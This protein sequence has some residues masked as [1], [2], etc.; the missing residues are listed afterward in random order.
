MKK[1]RRLITIILIVA[2]V[3]TSSI[4]ILGATTDPTVSQ[5]EL[6]N[7]DLS[8]QAATEG[9]VLF[10]ND[11]DAL[12][13][14]SS[15]NI[16]IFGAG[17]K[18]TVK[19]GTGSGAVNNRTYNF[20]GYDFASKT[21]FMAFD[22][23][24]YNITSS[25][26]YYDKLSNTGT[27]DLLLTEEYVQPTEA[28][29]T[30][31][32]VISRNSGEGSD[33][34]ATA[35]DYYLSETEI[36]NLNLLAS[37][38][39]TL[40]VVL[41]TGGM[42][43]TTAFKD[44]NEANPGS[45]DALL[46][47]SQAGI[48]GG[49]A[50]VQVL[51]GTVT[52]SGKLTDS[53][54]A[55]YDYYP[56][57][58]TFG[59]NDGNSTQEDYVEGIYVGY[60]YFDSFYKVANAD[61]PDSV[62][63]Y[64]FGYGLSY[65]DFDVTVDSV[66]VD[67]DYVTVNATVM[68]T[69]Q[70]YS[71]K[72]VVQ[73]YF[74]APA[75]KLDKPYQELGGYGKT[76]V[77]GPGQRQTLTISFPTTEMSSYDEDLEAYIMEDGD[78]IIRVGNSSRSTNVAAVL[79]LDSDLVTEYLSNQ[80]TD[81][82]L[83]DEWTS[84]PANHYSYT[85]EADEIA[86]ATRIIINTTGFVAPDNASEYE[87]NVVVG[88]DS[89]YYGMDK[90]LISSVNVYLDSNDTD[91][92]G[93]GTTYSL[94]TGE[95]AIDTKTV[96]DATLYD[97]Y[98]DEITLE[99]FVASLSVTQLANIVE[100]V[101]SNPN[102]STSAATGSAGFTTALYEDLGIPTMVMPDGPAGLRVTQSYTTDDVTYYQYATAWPI[103]TLL[104][105]TFNTELLQEVG[106]A[107]GGEMEELGGTWW[108]APGMN[109]HRDPLCGRNFE[110]YS[111]DPYLTGMTAT[112]MTLGVQ[113]V[114][115]MGVTLKHYFAN[116]QETSRT[117]ENN[118]ISQ[119]AM[120][121]I[122]LK[123]F[124]IGVKN[125][126]PMAIMSCYN[127]NNGT[128]T[129]G[130]YDSLVDILRGEWGF[131]GLVMTDWGGVRAGIVN[132]MYA[133]NDL[134]MPGGSPNDVINATLSTAA[135]FDVNGFPV[136]HKSEYIGV[137]T[138]SLDLGGFV[139]STDGSSSFTFTIDSS[140]DLSAPR[141][142]IAIENGDPQ[143][144]SGYANVN[145]AYTAL[146]NLLDDQDVGLT[147]AEKSAIAISDVVY[148]DGAV[149]SYSVTYKGYYAANMR[150]G[151]LQRSAINILGVMMDSAQ[152]GELADIQG[153]E[154]I[155]IESYTEKYSDLLSDPYLTIERGEVQ[156]RPEVESISFDV[157]SLTLIKKGQTIDLNTN[158][159]PIGAD[160]SVTYVSK[161]PSVATVDENGIVTA[162]KAGN[163]IITATSV[164]GK[165]STTTIRVTN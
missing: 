12:P 98:K 136:Y 60:R 26:D 82:H 132:C 34:S 102:P 43:D 97:V 130:D 30:A 90:D 112:A 6:N 19:G 64:P 72:E 78:Y 125:A 153:V 141:S 103:G 57:S 74:S 164:N 129:A 61:D 36:S 70:T 58:E 155:V 127:K 20:R 46:L 18:A 123:G 143:T 94:K 119:R 128:Y 89:Y 115:G 67:M 77:L 91:W 140:T 42:M 144:I 63:N 147:D 1:F 10:E 134:I 23:A 11:N 150:L 152:F 101:R 120:R 138:Y 145:E 41:N 99:Q 146:T 71:G 31:L 51:N 50:L 109:I 157:A 45:I 9:M 54:A 76:D 83:D 25:S 37:T 56:A 148:E 2:M 122:Y 85:G 117:S 55:S 66:T 65:T 49:K 79:T 44:I 40:I 52:P 24:G 47:M 151:D 139:L 114:P 104:A 111:E 126:Q 137:T 81:E 28:T 80:I 38:Y 62:L 39:E 110:Y 96:S 107:I 27:T 124:E 21:V 154:G 158:V 14:E 142:T 48:E 33:R 7:I 108:L 159:S 32:Y 73:V 113:S 165:T 118:T 161:N 22:E 17:A 135:D 106:E 100:G 3:L 116:N 4:A 69:G 29:D 156:A 53:W 35:G 8:I 5:R 68:N 133:G 160:S 93:S 149:V 163:S 16:A 131:R 86:A 84:D 59:R 87:Q 162:V 105:Q 15:G 92:E 13:I 75:G 121:E 95:V 88:E